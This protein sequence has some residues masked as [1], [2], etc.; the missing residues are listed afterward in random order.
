MRNYTHNR[1]TSLSYKITKLL[2]KNNLTVFIVSTNG[3]KTQQTENTNGE[4][5]E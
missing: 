5:H 3:E 2:R 4:K 1:Q